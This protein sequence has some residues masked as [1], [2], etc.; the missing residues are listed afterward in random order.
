MAIYRLLYPLT[1]PRIPLLTSPSLQIARVFGPL[2]MLPL[3]SGGNV[4]ITMANFEALQ[5]NEEVELEFALDRRLAPEPR[6]QPR[7]AFPVIDLGLADPLL[8]W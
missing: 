4:W 7:A 3:S 1:S 5:Q 2:V 6:P 8:C